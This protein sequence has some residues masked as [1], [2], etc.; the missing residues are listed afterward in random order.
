[1]FLVGVTTPLGFYCLL[2]HGKEPG[3][4]HVIDPRINT[5]NTV[6]LVFISLDTP[7]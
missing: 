6:S 2:S 3:K 7:N 1:M 4:Q 5:A